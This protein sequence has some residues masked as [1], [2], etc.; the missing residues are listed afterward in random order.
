M[1]KQKRKFNHDRLAGHEPAW[2]HADHAAGKRLR[3]WFPTMSMHGCN[4]WTSKQYERH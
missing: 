4:P 3:L 2:H 1:T